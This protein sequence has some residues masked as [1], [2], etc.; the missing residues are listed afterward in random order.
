MEA[1][2]SRLGRRALP[3]ILWKRGKLKAGSPPDPASHQPR[4]DLR[5]APV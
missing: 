1:D 3:L 4:R 2:M 5:A